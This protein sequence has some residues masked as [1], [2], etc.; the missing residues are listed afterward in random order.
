MTA[1]AFIAGLLA[2]KWLET[3][4]VRVSLHATRHLKLEN[5]SSPIQRYAT[6]QGMDTKAK[7]KRINMANLRATKILQEGGAFEEL[8]DKAGYAG[9]ELP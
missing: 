9:D 7:G 5:L 6:E 4:L 3:L 2:S 1:L 8:L